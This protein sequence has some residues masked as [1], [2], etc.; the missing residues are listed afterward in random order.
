MDRV[1]LNTQVMRMAKRA[2][3]APSVVLRDSFVPVPSLLSQLQVPEHQV[4]YGRRGTGK[5]HLLR[6]LGDRQASDGCLVVYLDL[7][8]AGAA[9]D[10]FSA[11]QESFAVHATQLLVD[12]LEQV[13]SQIYEQVLTDAWS[14]RLAELS[15]ALDALAE[16]ATRVRVVG[17]SELIT[18]QED[19]DQSTRTA[20]VQ[21]QLPD[22]RAAWQ[23]ARGRTSSQ[24]RTERRLDRGQ[25][26]HHVLLG[27][28]TAAIRGV[29]EA[30]DPAEL[31]LLVDEW[32]A[33]PVEVQLLL[34]DLL[35]RTFIA[36]NGV[37]VKISALHGRSRFAAQEDSGTI[38]DWSWAPTPPPRWTWTT[39]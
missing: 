29:V 15:V 31:W 20:S 6:Y 21:L 10:V 19:N 34:A 27:P 30:V 28:L 23:A 33:V 32:S 39:S 14:G 18:E 16:A 35:R 7:R 38:G 11:R 26:H 2:E 37:T 5:T 8:Q 13:H 9:E 1:V 17:E 3:K 24:R 22:P 12:V 4:V 25:E 36:V